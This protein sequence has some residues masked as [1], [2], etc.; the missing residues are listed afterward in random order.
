MAQCVRSEWEQLA[1]INED[2]AR[3][4]AAFAAEGDLTFAA[5]AAV[6]RRLRFAFV[7]LA[8]RPDDEDRAAVCV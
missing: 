8:A 2:W 5:F 6:W 3:L 7:H 1:A 4:R